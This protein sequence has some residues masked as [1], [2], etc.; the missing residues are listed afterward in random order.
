MAT[1]LKTFDDV[2]SHLIAL[3]QLLQTVDEIRRD[4][5]DVGVTTEI[6]QLEPRFGETLY[7][8]K[9]II[10][11]DSKLLNDDNNK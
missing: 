7:L 6:K 5:L 10:N 2:K 9:S 11:A 4:L 8:N 3:K 1:V